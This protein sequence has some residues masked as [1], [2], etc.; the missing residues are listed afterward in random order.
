MSGFVWHVDDPAR[1]YVT[2]ASGNVAAASAVATM[3]A[4][5]AKTNYATGF[6]ITAAGATT[7]LPVLATITGLIT[8][9]LTYVF[10]APAGVLVAATPLIVAFPTPIPASAVNVAIVL[11][12]PSLGSGNTHAAVVL[13]G[14]NA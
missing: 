7:A 5:A 14:F 10:V 13:H 3:A 4:V 9:T 12:L 8:G 6:Q 11:T 1:T 2:A